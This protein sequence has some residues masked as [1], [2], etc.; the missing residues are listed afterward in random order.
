MEIAQFSQELQK[1]ILQIV[2]KNFK[3][4]MSRFIK[5]KRIDQRFW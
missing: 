1:Q 5:G 2:L 3:V 4:S